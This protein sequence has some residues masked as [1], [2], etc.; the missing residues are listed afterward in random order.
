[1]RDAPDRPGVAGGTADRF[2]AGPVV[3]IG[4]A[5][6]E[7]AARLR[8]RLH[9]GAEGGAQHRRRTGSAR[10][11]EPPARQRQRDARTQRA[12]AAAGRA[13]DRAGRAPRPTP[14]GAPRPRCA[15]R[16]PGRDWRPRCAR[17]RRRAGR[18]RRRAA[19]A[20]PRAR[21]APFRHL[22]ARR[23]GRAGAEAL[24]LAAFA[25]RARRAPRSAGRRRC[26]AVARA[27]PRSVTASVRNAGPAAWNEGRLPLRQLDL[28]LRARP[29]DPGT[30]E[31]ARARPPSWARSADAGRQHG[32]GP[33]D[34]GALAAR[35]RARRV[36]PGVLD[37]RAPRCCSRPGRS[38]GPRRHPA[39]DE[40]RVERAPTSTGDRSPRGRIGG[41]PAGTAARHAGAVPPRRRWTPGAA[42]ARQLVEPARAQRWKARGAAAAGAA[43]AALS[44][45]PTR[46]RAGRAWQLKGQATLVDFDPALWWPGAEDSAV[47][48]G[49]AP[50]QRQ[51]R[52]RLTRARRPAAP[53]TPPPHDRVWP[54]A[55][56]G[57]WPTSRS[58]RAACSPACRATATL[59]LR[60]SALAGVPV[61]PT[62]RCARRTTAPPRPR[63]TRPRRNRLTPPADSPA[64][65]IGR[66]LGCRD[67]RRRAGAPGAAVAPGATV[68]RP[69]ATLAGAANGTLQ[70][71]R[72]LAGARHA[73]RGAARWRARWT[74]LGAARTGRA[75]GIGTAPGRAG[76]STAD[77]ERSHGRDDRGRRR[78]SCSSKAPAAIAPADLRAES[79]ASPPGWL[80]ACRA[81][82]TAGRASRR[83]RRGAATRKAVSCAD[84]A[85]GV[86]GWRGALQRLE[87]GS[88][89]AR[90]PRPG[91]A[92]AT[93]RATA[94]G[95]ID[96]IRTVRQRQ[97][98]AVRAATGPRRTAGRRHCAGTSCAGRPPAAPA[99]H[100][101]RRA[102]SSSRSRWRRCWQRLQP[103]F[104]WGGD[105]ARRR[106]A[107]T[108]AARRASGRVRARTPARRPQ[109][110]R[111]AGHPGARPDRPASR[112][113]RDRRRVELHPGRWPARRS[114]W[115]PARS[116]CAPRREA[117]WPAPQ[118]PVS[119]VLELQVANLGTWG[120]WVPAGWRLGG[121]LRASA[122]IGGRFGAPEYT[123][124]DR[125]TRAQRAQ[126]PARRERDRR[127]VSR[128]RCRA[129]RAHRALPARA[130]N[131]SLQL[132]GDA[133]FGAAPKAQ[134]ATWWPTV[135]AARPGRP[136]HRHQRQRAAAARRERLALDGQLRHRRRPDRLQPQR[137]TEPV[138]RRDVVRARRPVVRAPRPM[139]RMAQ[140]PATPAGQVR[141]R[142]DG[143][144]RQ[145]GPEAAPARPRP[146][147]R[148][149]RRPAHHRARTAGWQS[150]AR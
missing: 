124:D 101:R 65:R 132:T 149:A 56:A 110:D 89:A 27:P 73:R 22:A 30:L 123:G 138:G 34:R 127:R 122:C 80:T 1:M 60:D 145:P 92:P 84:A 133:S 47:A 117:A 55:A 148:A 143:P 94:M 107:S 59:A 39:A 79:Q 88:A 37:A 15:G 82:R 7:P 10:L 113:E 16:S 129:R 63:S 17:S 142:G 86:S 19:V 78:R 6:G 104:G 103:D 131:G 134:A 66:P 53:T 120:T 46:R 11:R 150:M 64:R 13:R 111:R 2:A 108:C 135:P 49:P 14:P 58:G 8:A 51:G 95:G 141:Q 45:R 5:S 36:Q 40:T 96:A 70:L 3:V 67:H 35:R 29:D 98:A 112:P 144:A 91:C 38:C 32:Q 99:R 25:A 115:P 50:L 74:A 48:R 28:D 75:G 52:L 90:L 116:W 31:R 26:A 43:R 93:W 42:G 83:Q 44:A 69:D 54:H 97:P 130:G 61:R 100:A 114:A 62:A 20:G 102:P 109:R 121:A 137:R 57:R 71:D 77:L 18:S 72:P 140:M 21:R 139:P 136:A 126:L 33:L 41:Q 128:S 76:G 9:L 4:S 23:P 119:G 85:G 87:V 147:H 146:R 106:R 24:D 105:L 81:R 68:A 118:T 125:G 12:A